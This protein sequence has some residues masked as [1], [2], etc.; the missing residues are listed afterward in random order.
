MIAPK[1][2][3]KEDSLQF[4]RNQCSINGCDGKFFSCTCAP[5]GAAAAS[6]ARAVAPAASGKSL[7][8]LGRGG[9]CRCCG[10]GGCGGGA[11]VVRHPGR[12][13]RPAPRR[14]RRRPWTPPTPS[15]AATASSRRGPSPPSPRAAAAAASPA[16]PAAVHRGDR[17]L[18]QAG[19]LEFRGILLP[20]AKR[21][22]RRGRLLK[23]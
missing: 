4:A 7:F 21:C 20:D 1:R 16:P 15:A 8:V 13:W 5:R 10:G 14:R 23:R 17:R 9:S 2:N 19:R 12:R 22:R 11:I 6:P 3:A 18:L